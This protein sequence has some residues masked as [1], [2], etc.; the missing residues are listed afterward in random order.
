MER[1]KDTNQP[2]NQPTN[3]ATELTLKQVNCVSCL[4]GG[5]LRLVNGPDIA[6]SYDGC[7]CYQ[8]R[9]EVS[10]WTLWIGSTD[11]I[12]KWAQV[13][14]DGVQYYGDKF[15]GG[16]ACRDLGFSIGRGIYGQGSQNH[17]PNFKSADYYVMNALKCWK[18]TAPSIF[19]CDY[20]T[21][22]HLSV[23][24][25]YIIDCSSDGI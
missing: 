12:D 10:G 9:L 21:G 1:K 25:E 5:W 14:D 2:T 23:H 6:P 8:G 22:Y 7:S 20:S 17:N 24:E 3:T 19:S 18:V 4:D 13:G 15:S 11:H 16:V